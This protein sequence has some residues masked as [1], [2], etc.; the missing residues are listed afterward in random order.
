MNLERFQLDETDVLAHVEGQPLSADREARL[1]HALRV[2]PA[3]ASVVAAMKADCAALASLDDVRAPANLLS[4]V[5]AA[6]ERE[7]LL[8][9]N[10]R[11]EPHQFGTIPVSKVQP[12]R[13]G[14][15][16]VV[17]ANPWSRRLAVAAGIALAAGLTLLAVR[18]L[19]SGKP[20]RE[21]A[22]GNPT[23]TGFSDPRTPERPTTVAHN[24]ETTR[25]VEGPA[26]APKPI[27]IDAPSPTLA[28]GPNPTPAPAAPN[29]PTAVVEATPA[30]AALPEVSLEEAVRLAR[31]GRLAVRIASKTPEQALARLDL[32]HTRRTPSLSVERLAAEPAGGVVATLYRQHD[33]MVAALHRSP[34][35]LV[36]PPAPHTPPNTVAGGGA[37]TT[38]QPRDNPASPVNIPDP[39]RPEYRAEVYTARVA[40]DE[41]SLK[42]LLKAV[43]ASQDG[44]VFIALDAA[45]ETAPSL[46]PAAVLWWTGPAAAWTPRAAVPVV[47]EQVK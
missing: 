4:Q 2:D 17:F 34:E 27:G 10:G 23:P 31:Q 37:P 42:A 29:P 36:G 15:V 11:A 43:A 21:L 8:G 24:P 45:S 5:E 12:R 13:Q 9:V 38:S 46:D 22:R 19:L 1:R 16:S 44:A 35:P 3:L 20:S 18:P 25:G 6:L 7:A 39:P 41:N 40:I 14:V 47:V 32:L 26:N 33:E 28:T 30:P